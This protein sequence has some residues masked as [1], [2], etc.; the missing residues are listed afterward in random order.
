MC[1]CVGQ[2]NEDSLTYA[3]DILDKASIQTFDLA[4][5]GKVIDDEVTNET[6]QASSNILAAI[7]RYPNVTSSKQAKR[8]VQTA[9]SVIH[10]SLHVRQTLSSNQLA[11]AA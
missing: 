9:N 7:S 11:T 3:S 8:I 1:V 4:S 5:S 6:L 2:L 10:N